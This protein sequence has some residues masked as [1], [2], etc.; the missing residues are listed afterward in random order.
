MSDSGVTT[1][2][3]GVVDGQVVLTFPKQTN[4]VAFDPE[5]ARQLGEA[6]AKN[7]YEARYGTPPQGKG[8]IVVD[9]I[10]TRLHLHATHMIRS[11]ID[12]RVL[13]GRIAHEVV[14]MVLRE[15]T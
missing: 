13:P 9:Q 15:V 6:M 11:M 4:W 14:D 7:A 10:R 8:S 2:T 5:T 12:K 3:I 1:C